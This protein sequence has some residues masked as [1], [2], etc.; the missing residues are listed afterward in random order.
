MHT[1]TC[2]SCGTTTRRLTDLILATRIVCASIHS[3]IF[4]TEMI[5]K[6]G[7]F[8][9]DSNDTIVTQHR[10]SKIIS[11]KGPRKRE[12]TLPPHDRTVASVIV[13]IYVRRHTVSSM[14][15]RRATATVFATCSA[16]ISSSTRASIE[17]SIR[18]IWNTS[19]II[20]ARIASCT[21]IIF[22]C[23]SGPAKWWKKNNAQTLYFN[24]VAIITV[25]V[26]NETYHPLGQEQV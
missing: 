14:L 23:R 2:I 9:T 8:N 17:R 1:Q 10:S 5:K 19:T 16:F 26:M 6:D 20:L 13:S 3:A 21:S 15:T 11:G 7:I 24:P 12:R 25:C 4:P 18:R 22:T